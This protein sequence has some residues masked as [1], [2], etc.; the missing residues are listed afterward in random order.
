MTIP[1]SMVC[2][3]LRCGHEWVKRISGRPKYCSGCKESNWD[4][5]AGKLPRG[6]PVTKKASKKGK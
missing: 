3:C 6:R 4:V 2:K 1:A 5:P